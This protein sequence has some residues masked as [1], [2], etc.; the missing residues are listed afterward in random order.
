MKKHFFGRRI[1]AMATTALIGLGC[2]I[3]AAHAELTAYSGNDLVP[4]IKVYVRIDAGG[5]LTT[6]VDGTQYTNKTG[7][8]TIFQGAGNA[9]GT[10]MFGIEGALQLTQDTQAVYK[11]ESGFNTSDG[12]FNGGKGLFNRR[13]YA[14]FSDDRYGT[15]VAGKDLFINNDIWGWD[16]ML[17]ETTSTATLVEGRSWPI[18][19]S[20]IEYRSPE[21]YAL[22]L[23][24]QASFDPTNNSLAS[25]QVNTST[26]LSDAA[27]ASLQYTLGNLNLLAIYDIMKSNSGYTNVYNASK[28]VIAAAKYNFDPVEVFVGFENLNAPQ[29]RQS[30]S[31]AVAV[32]DKGVTGANN[33]PVSSLLNYA[34]K[35]NMTWLGAAWTVNPK[36]ILRGAWYYTN[37]NGGVGH[38]NLVTGGGEYYFR[39]NMFFYTT[40]GEIVNQG[41]SQLSVETRNAPPAAGKSQ[42]TA[43]SGVS[44]AF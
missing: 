11:L 14:G 38:A 31:N 19:N 30:N 16:P 43:Y 18:V 32:N 12:T 27:G 26:H 3:P 22:K 4:S 25:P 37:V 1:A 15:L 41:K 42:F 24:L 29:G 35:A 33:Q 10:S 17:Q 13:A 23:G 5:A 40:V 21:T 9:W 2:A 6:G 44:I 20:M 7:K 39:P 28:E 36:L 8:R 34:T